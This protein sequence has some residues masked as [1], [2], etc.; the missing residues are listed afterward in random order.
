MHLLFCCF[1]QSGWISMLNVV[2]LPPRPIAETKAH[3]IL[4]IAFQR[5]QCLPQSPSGRRLLCAP[6]GSFH[7]LSF[8][9]D[10]CV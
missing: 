7:S 10:F 5:Q 2:Y 3:S 1:G 9:D 6:V 4:V 8:R